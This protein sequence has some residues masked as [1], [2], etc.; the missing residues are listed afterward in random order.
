MQQSVSALVE[1]MS[2]ANRKLVPKCIS[3]CIIASSSPETQFQLCKDGAWEILLKWLQ[4]AL[5]EDNYA[6]LLELLKVYLLLPVRL[7]QLT[8]NVCPKLINS[9]TKRCDHEEVKSVA[10]DIVKKWKDVISSDSRH[11]VSNHVKRKKIETEAKPC[12]TDVHSHDTLKDEKKRRTTVKIPPNNMRTAGMEDTSTQAQPK[13]RSDILAKRSKID[14][15]NCLT[16]EFPIESFHQKITVTPT[17]PRKELHES[18]DFIN[19]LTT[20]PCPVVRKKRKIS[21]KIDTVLQADLP[22]TKEESS[23][24]LSD[25][26]F[27]ADTSPSSPK[28]MGSKKSSLSNIYSTF[29]A[30]NKPKK[31][32]SWAD[33][34]KLQSFY[35]FEL[36]ESERGKLT[37][38]FDHML[39][40]AIIFLDPNFYCLYVMFYIVNVNRVSIED[41]RR[42]EHSMERQLFKRSHEDTE[43]YSQKWHSPCQLERLLLVEP[44]CKSIERQ[45]QLE[46]ERCVLQA[47]YFTRESIPYS[48]E[49]PDMEVVEHIPPLDIPLDDLTAYEVNEKNTECKSEK[50][51]VLKDAMGNPQMSLNPEVANLVKSLAANLTSSPSDPVQQMP[52]QINPIL[53]PTFCSEFPSQPNTFAPVF[54]D[55]EM[56]VTSP[57]SESVRV[58]N[59]H[60]PID[61]MLQRELWEV[62]EQNYPDVNVHN[63]SAERIRDL[64]E[65]LRDQLVARGIFQ[66]RNP[67]PP[68]PPLQYLD[69]SVDS[70]TPRQAFRPPFRGPSHMPLAIPRSDFTPPPHGPRLCPPNP[71]GYGPTN[72]MSNRPFQ[73]ISPPVPHFAPN[74]MPPYN[75]PPTSLRAPVYHRGNPRIR[76]GQP[77]KFF[78]QGGCR[79]GQSCSFMHSR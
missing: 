25:Q 49:E 70:P 46:R 60:S 68:K 22:T 33:E 4:E 52:P 29:P 63:L 61:Q 62:L 30:E 72:R 77:C 35:Y 66:F 2:S 36:D 53:A 57:N 27:V 23:M 54:S 59:T 51:L 15:D 16:S 10:V 67:C 55:T 50:L 39:L 74:S 5:K 9:L 37:L 69:F 26:S 28:G 45:I 48:P 73:P 12:N 1:L 40:S 47:I 38:L 56:N 8:Q 21:P 44:G 14:S 75:G 34:D 76:N 64:L 71:S 41:I 13:S 78:Q 32:V 24:E 11:L 58:I 43:V 19:A 42:K 79:N 3:L 7:E 6:F 18:S 20:A 17:E 31:R 65:P